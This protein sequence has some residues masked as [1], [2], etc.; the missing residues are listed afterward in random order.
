MVTKFS[1]SPTLLVR[2]GGRTIKNLTYVDAILQ[3]GDKL[4]LEDIEKAK[5]IAGNS[6]TN[7]LETTFLVLKDDGTGDIIPTPR[8]TYIA[9]NRGNGN[10]QR[11]RGRG[12]W[13]GRGQQRGTSSTTTTSSTN[14]TTWA[15][16]VTGANAIPVQQ[17]IQQP[18]QQ[19]IT[20]GEEIQHSYSTLNQNVGYMMIP[21][22]QATNQYQA[23]QQQA[24]I[25]NQGLQ[26]QQQFS[27]Q[28]MVCQGIPQLHAGQN[29]QQIQRTN[30]GYT[31]Q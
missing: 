9:P 13:R 27:T 26:T 8:G 17:T 19:P 4:S 23:G 30:P 31:T 11:G 2:N 12:A 28:G 7:Q 14:R 10:N 16:I 1:D 25:L 3:Y 15:S 6:F 29:S 18:T 22:S 5:K 24:T 21:Q 20:C